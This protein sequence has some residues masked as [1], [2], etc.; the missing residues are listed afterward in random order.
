MFCEGNTLENIALWGI[1]LRKPQK[2]SSLEITDHYFG[3]TGISATDIWTKTPKKNV[4]ILKLSFGI[5][6]NTRENRSR[7][8]DLVSIFGHFSEDTTRKS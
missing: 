7:N 2:Q 1:S 3:H 8:D 4:C 6:E 5:F